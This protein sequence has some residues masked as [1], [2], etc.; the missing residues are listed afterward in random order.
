MQEPT[1]TRE[2]AKDSRGFGTYAIW[3]GVVLVLYVLSW[4]PARTMYWRIVRYGT[5]MA[6]A[7]D[8]VYFPIEWAENNTPLGKPLGMYLNLWVP[9]RTFEGDV[10]PIR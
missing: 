8:A 3:A 9:K 5:P 4:G 7:I 2:E 10:D 1:E 6:R